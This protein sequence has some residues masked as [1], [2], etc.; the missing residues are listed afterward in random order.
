MSEGGS[1]NSSGVAEEDRQWGVF[2]SDI[3][4]G[5]TDAQLAAAFSFVDVLSARVVRDKRTDETK[6]TLW[7]L[8]SWFSLKRRGKER[9]WIVQACQSQ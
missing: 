5:T 1:G 6:G 7:G 3:A 8:V 9:T 2:V 4:K